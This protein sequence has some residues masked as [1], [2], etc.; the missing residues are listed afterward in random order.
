MKRL[1]TVIWGCA[2]AA[3]TAHADTL[4]SDDFQDGPP[5]R[6]SIVGKGDVQ[7][8]RYAGNVSMRLAGPAAAVTALSVAGFS[9]VRV[10]VALAAAG[11]GPQDACIVDVSVDRGAT[12]E[13]VFRIGHGQ[14]DGVTLHR[15][16]AAPAVLT[17]AHQVVLRVRAAGK[18][19]DMTCWV[20]DIAV[21]GDHLVE[22]GAAAVREHLS[23]AQLTG[24]GVLKEPVPMAAFAPTEH[25]TPATA[26]FSGRLAFGVTDEE[27]GFRLLTDTFKSASGKDASY[28]IPPP[29]DFGFVQV[30]DR[31]VPIERGSQPSAHAWWEWIVGPGKTWHE[32]G[33]GDWNRASLPFALQERNANCMHDGVLTFLYRG[34]GEVSRVAYQ[35][36][37]ETCMY[38]K[39]DAWG[40]TRAKRDRQ[41]PLGA[42]ALA[43]AYRRE[44]AGRML[45]KPISALAIDHPGIDPNQFGSALEVAPQQLTVFGV[46]VDG[47]HYVGGC[48]TRAGLY[49]YCDELL[50]PSYSVAK[51][52]F[53][54]FALMRLELLYPGAR[55]AKVVD[56]V[57]ACR[58]AHGWDGV[59]FDNLLDMG[60][61]R[62]DSRKREEDEN[63]SVTRPFFLVED[64]AEKIRLACTQYPRREAPGKTWVY[65]TSD[66]YILGAA[67][68]AFWRQRHGADA[69]LYRELLVD[70]V[71]SRLGLSPEV[72][73]PRRTRDAAAQ[74]FTGWGLTLRRDDVAK[75]GRFLAVDR[76]RL[77][78]ERLLDT[79]QV[80]AALQ[81]SAADPGLQAGSDDL[82]YNNGVWAWDAG[83]YLGCKGRA[84]IPF[85]S[86]FGGISVVM[87]P[88][89]V[90]YYYFS[91][92][93]DFRWAR[94]V[95]E[96]QKIGT[97]CPAVTP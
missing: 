50:L 21:V 53:A 81:R 12:W 34:T 4:F 18:G 51:T 86:G 78:D 17:G 14:D 58:A 19:S 90:V 7:L 96:S 8:T 5:E 69:D 9:N 65:H 56:Y 83:S 67:M 62:Y 70:P 75:L 36:S 49:P 6:W 3:G 45:V 24:A 66:T 29:F 27:A 15:G 52:V 11:L 74:P 37:Q 46:V 60:S 89:G 25:A 38:F 54:G 13:E 91:D 23:A 42:A 80:E 47:T 2:L 63:N 84:W 28:R 32:P 39:F 48:E 61:G 73:V 33:D 95:S 59:T 35:V 92:N 68:R 44:V 1:A 26:T 40:V 87:I 85:M 10:S 97:V 94:A 77:G 93:G 88:N 82:R 31:L 20:D 57:P 76:G 41:N 43:D 64:H 71:W 55:N 22:P 79:G 72:S 30:D 16:G